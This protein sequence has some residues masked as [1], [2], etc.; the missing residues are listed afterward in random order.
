[1]K[2]QGEAAG[3]SMN[4]RGFLI[5]LAGLTSFLL[6]P[7]IA[8]SQE[9]KHFYTLSEIEELYRKEYVHGPR[10][11]NHLYREGERYFG[12]LRKEKFEV[13]ARFIE[14]TLKHIKTMLE[15][16][17]AKYIFR[18]DAFHAHPMLPETILSAKA[19]R[20][21]S[22]SLNRPELALLFHNSEFIKNDP[23]HIETVELLQK[24]NVIGW[25]DDNIR[26]Q[27]LMPPKDNPLRG[28]SVDE[29]KGY[30]RCFYQLQ[31]SANKNGEFLIKMGGIEIR[32]DFSFDAAL[33]SRD[34]QNQ[35]D[36]IL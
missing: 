23:N 11:E 18:L 1:M 15:K 17:A 30:G 14:I 9:I 21:N 25:Y 16:R 24:R 33:E 20:G 4:R 2:N 8:R 35:N 28:I 13:P 34:H 29:I 10:L 36:T 3:K 6:K 7:E 31:F 32:L 26:I 19:L 27:I 22:L 5:N 12:S